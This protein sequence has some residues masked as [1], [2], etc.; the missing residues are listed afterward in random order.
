MSGGIIFSNIASSHGG[1]LFVSGNDRIFF[2]KTGGTIFGL[3]IGDNSSNAVQN[4]SGIQKNRGHAI[5]VQHRVN[6][7]IKKRE[8][9]IE[10]NENISY[11]SR[12]NPPIVTGDWDWDF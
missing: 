7:H 12:S 5:F 11:S 10:I 3:V 2:D 9:T 6:E 8:S 4:D 1:G